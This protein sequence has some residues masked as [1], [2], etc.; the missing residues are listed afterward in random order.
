MA[1][2]ARDL[3]RIIGTGR[4][5]DVLA[6]GCIDGAWT[7]ARL[8]LAI[9]LTALNARFQLSHCHSTAR[10]KAPSRRRRIRRGQHR[11]RKP[12]EVRKDAQQRNAEAMTAVMQKIAAFGIPKDAI[13]TT[14]IDLQMEFDYANGSRR[15]AAMSRATPL[16]SASTTCEARR[17]ARRGRR[18]GATMI[19]GLRFDVKQ[20]DQ[21]EAAALQSA[22]KNAMAKAQAI[23]A[24][25][26]ARR[27]HPEDRR[28]VSAAEP[29]P[30]MRQMAM[31]SADAATPVAPESSRSRAVRSRSQSNRTQ[32]REPKTS[33][34]KT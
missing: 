32:A 5:A 27:S 16:K 8:R 2:S 3:Q 6:S 13:K 30:M 22:V 11:R 33:G 10:V 34:P 9:R 31:A 14:A 4:A 15:R 26:I 1:T 29:V 28:T 12:L 19:H 23:A 7:T 17:R 25:P 24:D 20:R 18:F 21:L